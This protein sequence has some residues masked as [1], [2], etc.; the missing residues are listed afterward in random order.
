MTVKIT[1]VDFEFKEGSDSNRIPA[2]VSFS[3]ALKNPI[4]LE[5]IPLTYEQFFAMGLQLPPELP[6]VEAEA[7]SR[8]TSVAQHVHI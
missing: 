5:F 6:S 1:E 7:S 8:L 3:T 4:D 2:R